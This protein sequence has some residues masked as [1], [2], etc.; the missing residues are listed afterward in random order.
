MIKSAIYPGT[1]DPI[2][3]GHLNV[4]ER[5]CKLFDHVYLTI[6]IN[7]RK[8]PLFTLDERKEL[9]LES[10]KHIPNLSI[11]SFDGLLVRFAEEKNAI[12][13]VRGIR[14]VT[15]FEYEFQIAM[16][17]HK[18]SPEIITV[19]LMPN[20]KYTY[21]NSSIIREVSRLGGNVSDLVPPPVLNKLQLKFKRG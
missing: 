11:E 5:A 1:F 17:N 8:T 16:M 7:S 2:T 9:I 14:Q 15:D 12:S 18:L 21:L 3:Y 20:E 10:T 6:A 13:I 4:L 19:F